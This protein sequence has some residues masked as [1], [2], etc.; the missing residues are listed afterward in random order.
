KPNKENSPEVESGYRAGDGRANCLDTTMPITDPFFERWSPR[1]AQVVADMALHGIRR[2]V[3]GMHRRGRRQ[4]TLPRAFDGGLGNLF[5][6]EQ[7]AACQ[8]GNDALTMVTAGE[9]HFSVNAGRVSAQ[10]PFHN[11]RRL[12]QGLPV[13]ESERAET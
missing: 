3:R 9:R 6:R 13:N 11:A 12:D 10:D 7:T 8:P 5:L 1:T 4:W 2:R